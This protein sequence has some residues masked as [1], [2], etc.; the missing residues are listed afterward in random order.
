MIAIAG[1][2]EMLRP[3]T[4]SDGYGL[5]KIGLKSADTHPDKVGNS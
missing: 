5:E 4:C 2:D 3:D 1:R